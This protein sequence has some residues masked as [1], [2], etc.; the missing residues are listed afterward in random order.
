MALRA[1]NVSL[2]FEKQ[3]VHCAEMEWRECGFRCHNCLQSQILKS[4]VLT[5]KRM[6][7]N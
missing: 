1:Q 7:E 5:K 3:E 2:A 4:S 6:I